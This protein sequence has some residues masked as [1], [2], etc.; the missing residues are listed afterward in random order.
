M[1]KLASAVFSFNGFFS[2]PRQ[3]ELW[4]YVIFPKHLRSGN[5]A[6]DYPPGGFQT[7]TN[8]SLIQALLAFIIESD[9]LIECAWVEI[10]TRVTLCSNKNTIVIG[11]MVVSMTVR[12]IRP[13]GDGEN[14][15][16]ELYSRARKML[17]KTSPK[18]TVRVVEQQR[19]RRL[20]A[21]R[22]LMDI[23]GVLFVPETTRDIEITKHAN[24][25]V[26]SYPSGLNS[27]FANELMQFGSLMREQDKSPSTTLNTMLEFG[28][29]AA[30]PN[31]DAAL[32]MSLALLVTN[33]EWGALILRLVEKFKWK[34][35]QGWVDRLSEIW[36][37][38]MWCRGFRGERTRNK[39]I[40][41]H[42]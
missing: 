3:P 8:C 37:L 39:T 9:E 21:Y 13:G 2:Q 35:E 12:R 34:W 4:F 23:F 41:F 17:L 28:L 6:Q 11:L 19:E 30:F 31:L 14:L 16:K 40:A 5:P 36:T 18:T 22:D 7:T 29:Q 27:C 15:S 33:C 25:C 42:H 1:M 32:R 20:S 10:H 24:A 38:L 26:S